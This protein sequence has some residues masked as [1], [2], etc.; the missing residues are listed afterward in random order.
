[1]DDGMNDPR[2]VFDSAFLAIAESVDPS[3]LALS[4]VDQFDMDL[5]ASMLGLPK[6]P[7][8]V[9]ETKAWSM[10]FEPT[11]PQSWSPRHGLAE[12]L[13]TILYERHPRQFARYSARLQEL[14]IGDQLPDPLSLALWYSRYRSDAASVAA[15]FLLAV[16]EPELVLDFVGVL[17][18]GSRTHSLFG[19]SL[20]RLLTSSE[21]WTSLLL[22]VA[23]DQGV[24]DS[25]RLHVR[26][27]LRIL[28]L[29]RARQS[30]KTISRAEGGAGRAGLVRQ[31]RATFESAYLWRDRAL[32][33]DPGPDTRCRLRWDP[34]P[35]GQE[36]TLTSLYVEREIEGRS[37]PQGKAAPGLVPFE[38]VKSPPSIR[39][40]NGARGRSAMSES[41]KEVLQLL[42]ALAFPSTEVESVS[43][44]VR[45]DSPRVVERQMSIVLRPELPIE[46]AARGLPGH[47]VLWQVPDVAGSASDLR[48]TA[49]DGLPLAG[50]S[51]E[52]VTALRRLLDEFLDPALSQGWSTSEERG[53]RPIPA[54]Y[55]SRLERLSSQTWRIVQRP[56]TRSEA[57]VRVS[58]TEDLPQ[59]ISVVHALSGRARLRLQT[60]G[61]APTEAF[62]LEFELPSDLAVRSASLRVPRRRTRHELPNQFTD[63]TFAAQVILSQTARRY[64]SVVPVAAGALAILVALLVNFGSPEDVGPQFLYVLF[65]AIPALFSVFVEARR[66]GGPRGW[67]LRGLRVLVVVY[68]FIAGLALVGALVPLWDS[69]HSA[70]TYAAM[71]VGVLLVL[72]GIVTAAWATRPIRDPRSGLAGSPSRGGSDV[73]WD[74]S[75]RIRRAERRFRARGS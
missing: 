46:E 25:D 57:E 74:T 37:E 51:D 52:T 53:E 56:S 27:L 18:E 9:V 14:L 67:L 33:Q 26:E 15:P 60:A 20:R 43:H 16:D 22:R 45:L 69:A 21:D 19:Y 11:G 68:A 62:N 40:L 59:S 34:V 17:L 73:S 8:E 36:A 35:A 44:V 50:P 3:V 63:S 66:T 30:G 49:A 58:W 32:A 10:L 4:L 38:G 31:T 75:D 65:A 28:N 13:R 42:T 23:D 5:A 39:W 71:G 6:V 47:I 24:S 70:A 55:Y 72:S 54:S 41:P 1:M 12:G 29:E 64:L 2:S 7:V 61:F 48:I